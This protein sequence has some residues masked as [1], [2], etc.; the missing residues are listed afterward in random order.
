[1]TIRGTHIHV[2]RKHLQKY[3]DECSFRYVHRNEGQLMFNT[4]LSQVV[5]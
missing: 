3:A 2:S 4:I 1:M 5:A